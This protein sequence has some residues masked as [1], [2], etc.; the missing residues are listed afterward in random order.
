MSR[1]S[2]ALDGFLCRDKVILRCNRV[3]PRHEILGRDIVFSYRN[4]V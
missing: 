1:Q 3:W 2:L 4:L